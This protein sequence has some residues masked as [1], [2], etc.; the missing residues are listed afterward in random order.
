M[1]RIFAPA[2]QCFHRIISPQCAVV[3]AFGL[4]P[5]QAFSDDHRTCGQGWSSKEW[6]SVGD[7]RAC[8]RRKCRSEHVAGTMFPNSFQQ[9][10]ITLPISSLISLTNCY[11]KQAYSRSRLATTWTWWRRFSLAHSANITH[12][13]RHII[14][15]ARAYY[16]YIKHTNA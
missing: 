13:F 6:P 2:G 1:L 9:F 8:P 5:E 11:L 10:V 14:S 3:I 16:F 4:L 7:D 15:I 12:I